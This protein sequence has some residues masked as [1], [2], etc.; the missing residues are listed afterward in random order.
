MSSSI[1]RLYE[2]DGFRLD[3]AERLLVRDGRPVPLTPKAFEM[4]V[5]LASNS[6]RLLTKDE[7]MRTVWA[8]AVVEE[9]NLDKNISALRKALGENG[10]GR[11]FIET[12]RG[13]GYRFNAVVTEIAAGQQNGA[14]PTTIPPS[15]LME[16]GDKKSSAN[17]WQRKSAWGLTAVLLLAGMGALRFW[18]LKE[19]Q[20]DSSHGISVMRL[21]NGGY[22][23][24]AALSPDGKYFAYT[25]QDGVAAHLWLRQ[26]AGG[27]PIKLVPETEQTILG[28][29]FAPDGQAIYFTA[30][31]QGDP[32]GAVYRVSTLGGAVTK[33]L[34]GVI[35]PVAL[36]PD[37]RQ[38]AFIRIE[39]SWEEQRGGNN[40]VLADVT[41]GNE[42]IVLRR[43]GLERFGITGPAWSPD[44]KEITCQILSGM[45]KTSDEVW[46]VVGVDIQSGAQRLLTTQQW[47]GCG[48]IAWL[49]DGHGFVMVGTKQ[50]EGVTTARDSVW[51]IS[52]PDGAIRRITTDLSRHN[53]VS[54]SVT[55]DG[56]S[57][58][59]IPFNRTSQIWSVEA[60]GQGEKMRYDAHTVTQLTT[61]T[62]DGR[63]GIISLGDGRVVY[64]ARTG[65][66]VDLWRM[67]ID[68]SQQQQLTTTPPFLEE[69]S[70]PTDGSFFVFASNHA[71]Y[72]HLFRVNGDGTNLRQLTSGESREIESDCSPDGRW[73]VYPSK[74]S[75]PGKIAE[76][77]LWKIPAEGGTPIS[78]TDHEAQTP[79][80]SPDGQWISYGYAD[81][82]AGYVV[83]IPAG[84]GAPVKT[85]KLP[86]STD[87]GVG[88]RWTPD[89][90]GLT[91]IVKGKTFDNLW[92]QPVDGRAPHA[93][94]DFN[95][96]EIYNYAFARNGQ[97]LFLARGYSI[98]D[99]SLIRDFR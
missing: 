91:Y 86:N 30:L 84:G 16:G 1:K 25:E 17:V 68:G 51:F 40:L 95:S 43:G 36:S 46:R 49:R 56:Q 21:T 76:F 53:Y 82:K 50:G 59:V 4:L 18:P 48:R 71:G 92:L 23:R 79:H 63:A 39:G 14:S 64:V 8:D 57:L 5:V 20:P 66:H 10:A 81:A 27:Q 34:T 69:A 54:V 11:K 15:P 80:F 12:V 35:S 74:S 70:A 45:T 58:L 32:Q 29:T 60:R 37:G 99:V 3:P 61:G 28:L 94:T 6:G 26:V 78:L 19:R 33:V 38:L 44:G 52:Q 83:I 55:D 87:F 72:S 65:E 13:H 9:N 93:L 22:I 98:R 96:G 90:Q 31:G 2:F 97:R 75:L 62:G 42:R 89:G 24:T 7:L 67:N 73:I 88:C 77:N 85:F 41:G 47:D